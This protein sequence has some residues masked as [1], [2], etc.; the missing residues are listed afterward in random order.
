VRFRCPECKRQFTPDE[1]RTEHLCASCG[2]LHEVPEERLVIRA[3]PTARPLEEALDDW[4]RGG[5]TDPTP[6][7]RRAKFDLA[8]AYGLAGD[9]R[10]ATELLDAATQ[11]PGDDP[12]GTELLRWRAR[13][14]LANR[15]VVGAAR[16]LLA[17][18]VAGTWDESVE[19]LAR[20]L[21]TAV[22]ADD[23]ARLATWLESSLTSGTAQPA[24]VQ[25]RG[26]VLDGAL[27]LLAGDADTAVRALAAATEADLTTA[28]LTWRALATAPPVAAALQ[29][30]PGNEA[31]AL[32]LSARIA[33]SLGYTDEASELVARVLDGQLT[34]D[35]YPEAEAYMLRGHD[36]ARP[37]SE[38][39]RDLLE[40]ARRLGWR[41][42]RSELLHSL[43]VAAEAAE[44]DPTL[45]EAYWLWADNQRNAAYQPDGNADQDGM[46]AALRIWGKG[47]QL[48]PPTEI[49]PRLVEALICRELAEFNMPTALTLSHRALRAASE[50]ALTDPDSSWNWVLISGTAYTL[51]LC[52]TA[53]FSAD[54]SVQL[55]KDSP[56]RLSDA[57]TTVI[58]V[59]HRVAPGRV[60][61]LIDQLEHQS[62]ATPW[63]AR[64]RAIIDLRA[65][66]L[67]RAKPVLRDLLAKTPTDDYHRYWYMRSLVLSG[68]DATSAFLKETIRKTDNA[69]TTM[70]SLV[71][72]WALL[73]DGRAAE[74]ADV[75]S[76]L[77]QYGVDR[78]LE[79]SVT[80]GLS[81][82]AALLLGD[83]SEAE[84]L[85]ETLLPSL[86]L[87]SLIDL[88]G[89]LRWIEQQLNSRG[90]QAGSACASRIRVA[91]ERA[92]SS[93]PYQG[94]QDLGSVLNEL[95]RAICDKAVSPEERRAVSTAHLLISA[96]D[97]TE[98]DVA[99]WLTP[100]AVELGENLVPTDSRNWDQWRLFTDIIPRMRAQLHETIGL[101]P[102]AVRVW[103]SNDLS[104]LQFRMLL[105]GHRVT[106]GVARQPDVIPESQAPGTDQVDTAL[107]QQVMDV[108]SETLRAR[109]S[110]LC[111][112]E[113]VESLLSEWAGG[114]EQQQN[115]A[116]RL[117][118]DREACIRL[119][120]DI[121][122]AIL[123]TGRVPRWDSELR[124]I[125]EAALGLAAVPVSS[126]PA[127]V[128]T[129]KANQLAADKAGDG[130][131]GNDSKH[132][133]EDK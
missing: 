85:A 84:K 35:G 125:A 115:L 48:G 132:G 33:S 50:C 55:A 30:N 94:P 60:P 15:D 126:T 103:S 8:R 7:L 27:R 123:T 67:D 16:A 102:P 124:E 41:D 18:P 49:W 128:G 45:Q 79:A 40:A 119:W 24:V 6:M 68:D 31:A 66:Q 71:R 17:L 29:P 2:H 57:L 116:E 10:R 26:Q 53:V 75:I 54:L 89:E 86:A 98:A 58:S 87:G 122:A 51:N 28:R 113:V 39:A 20:A 65:G 90:D 72:A 43:Q 82:Q 133:N 127:T 100:L 1:V 5:E 97:R 112:P 106:E 77:Q 42:N 69:T 111:T 46:L 59:C 108:V 96:H 129:P 118:G 23:A 64:L 22:T 3:L 47:R 105:D 52:S 81:M 32:T 70:T 107:W 76:C 38:R 101:Y 91:A 95:E 117:K 9:W 21:L 36:A 44:L 37:A 13:A 14:L 93:A 121:Y 110:M 25:V 73:W 12:A 34:G 130:G 83:R 120:R 63:T 78:L 61:G 104:P 56:E 80:A 19:G 131:A 74:A 99:D 4:L 88:D 11:E 114:T 92:R 62:G 109:P